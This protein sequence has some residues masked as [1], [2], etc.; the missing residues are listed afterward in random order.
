MK[1]N[2]PGLTRLP[3]PASADKVPVRMRPLPKRE[4]VSF[5][6][7]LEPQMVQ[8]LTRL[9]KT[10]TRSNQRQPLDQLANWFAGQFRRCGAQTEILKNRE[11]GNHLLARWTGSGSL[12]K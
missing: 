10:E 5:F 9:V 1:P 6:R 11:A 4:L 2:Q 3:G 8:W 7:P 12:R